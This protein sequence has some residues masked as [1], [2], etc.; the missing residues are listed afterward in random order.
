[1]ILQMKYIDVK[2]LEDVVERK[3]F[4]EVI[5]KIRC[6]RNRTVRNELRG[7]RGS[8]S[9]SNVFGLGYR[10]FNRIM[11]RRSIEVCSNG[12]TGNVEGITF[13]NRPI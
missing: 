6:G 4:D 9:N 5:Q 11:V 3:L 2:Y 13:L 7:R 12:S 8:K 10:N 1:M